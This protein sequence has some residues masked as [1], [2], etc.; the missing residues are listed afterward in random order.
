MLPL[1]PID[2]MST[3]LSTG[4]GLRD[5]LPCFLAAAVARDFDDSLNLCIE[6]PSHSMM[7]VVAIAVY[8]CCQWWQTMKIVTQ[9]LVY[10]TIHFVVDLT[11]AAVAADAQRPIGFEPAFD[12][13]QL[14]YYCVSF[15]YYYNDYVWN[16]DRVRDDDEPIWVVLLDRVVHSILPHF[17]AMLCC[18]D[19]LNDPNL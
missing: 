16:S 6:T 12:A 4:S 15:Y 2:G 5:L 7:A 9:N 13:E 18:N 10:A 17:Y 1:C 3:D 19:A 14:N 8:H 11:I